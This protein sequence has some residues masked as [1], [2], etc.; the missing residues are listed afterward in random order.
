MVLR[1]FKVNGTEAAKIQGTEAG[2]SPEHKL[3]SS[4]LKVRGTEAA[5]IQGLELVKCRSVD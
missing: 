2:Q 5:K 1:L 4:L 3:F